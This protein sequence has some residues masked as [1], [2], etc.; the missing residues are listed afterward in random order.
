[1]EFLTVM[2]GDQPAIPRWTCFYQRLLAH[3]A[4]EAAEVL[5][6]SLRDMPLE[7]VYDS[8]LIPA[9]V[10][11]EED[12]QDSDLD[13]PSI[14]YIRNRSREFIEELGF[15]ANR[16]EAVHDF[17]PITAGSDAPTAAARVM[18]IP[19]RDETDELAAM[20]AAQV[21]D[22]PEVHAFS[23]PARRID[24]ILAKIDT[25][26][27]TVVVLS[28]LPP[29]GLARSHRI[30]RNIRANNPNVRILIGIWN[31]PDDPA[32]AAKKISGT[33]EGRVWTRLTDALAEVRLV[34]GAPSV[35]DAG[36]AQ[37]RPAA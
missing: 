23:I 10:K 6:T 37:N 15:R 9:L 25:E 22:G 33:E 8:V 17:T 13:E 18:C 7:E 12:R 24:E 1:M 5:E 14:R 4:R 20:M 32:D 16:G 36:E 26:N 30:Y 21:L 31:Y 29:V 27:P 19:V 3:D 35:A 11:S 2:L 34:A 28:A